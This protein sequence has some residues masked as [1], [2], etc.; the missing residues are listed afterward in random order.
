MFFFISQVCISNL[1]T[2]N[3][4]RSPLKVLSMLFIVCILC[5]CV[6]GGGSLSILTLLPG[7]P[8]IK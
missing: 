1:H 8:I 5:V 7:F 4:T 3:A 2:T 6:C